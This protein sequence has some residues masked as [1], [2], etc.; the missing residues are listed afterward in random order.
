MN[1]IADKMKKNPKYTTLSDIVQN[2]IEKYNTV[3]N[4]SI[5]A[6]TS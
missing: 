6:E 1:I 3:G 5:P 2:L 4:G